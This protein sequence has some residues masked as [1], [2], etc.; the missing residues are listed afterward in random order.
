MYNTNYILGDVEFYTELMFSQA[1]RFGF[2]KNA[3]S[4]DFG[5]FSANYDFKLSKEC[6]EDLIDVTF[7][8]WF[9]QNIRY[10]FPKK[11]FLWYKNAIFAVHRKYILSR[12]KKDYINILKQFTGVKNE[13]D[14]FMER[15]WYYLLNLDK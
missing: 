2:S 6:K 9:E 5:S 3:F 14:H 8:N 1:K 13:T 12:P 15:S 4:Y 7:G 11:K 10:P